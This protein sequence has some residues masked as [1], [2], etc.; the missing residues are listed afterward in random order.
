MPLNDQIF[1]FMKHADIN[2][3][4]GARSS[5]VRA[6]QYVFDTVFGDDLP[7]TCL[8]SGTSEKLPGIVETLDRAWVRRVG[9]QEVRPHHR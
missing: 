4:T 7:S 8:G 5:T 9:V 6:E 2:F 3:L 1:E